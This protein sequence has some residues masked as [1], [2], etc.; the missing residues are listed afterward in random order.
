MSSHS[1]FPADERTEAAGWKPTRFAGIRY[2]TLRYDRDTGAGTVL[3]EMAPGTTYGAHRHTAGE[4]VLVLSG[5]LLV[6]DER[7]AAGAHLYSPP[8]S[9]HAPRTERG[10]LLFAVFPGKVEHL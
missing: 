1:L 2:R 5:E 7:F 3:L 6:G 10:C 9:V 4:D 8:G